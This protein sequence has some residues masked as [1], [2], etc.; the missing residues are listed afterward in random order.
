MRAIEVYHNKPIFYS[1]GDFVIQLYDVAIAPEDFYKK[2]GLDSTYSAIELLEKRSG[3]FK[4]GLMEDIR[5]RESV[6]P[7]WETDENKNLI[8]LTL[9]P[10]TASLGQGRHLEGLPQPSRETKFIDYLAKLSA[11]Y[12]VNITL[13]NGLAI[14]KW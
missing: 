14:C 7:Y 13:E 3:G 9:M 6:I 5:M 1:L 2:Y 11:P 4:R 12:G 8:S 10:V